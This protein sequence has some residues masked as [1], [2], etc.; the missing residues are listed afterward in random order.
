MQELNKKVAFITGGTK[1]IG[2]GIAEALLKER[3]SIAITGRQ[4]K[5]L[6]PVVEELSRQARQDAKILGFEDD[7]RTFEDLQKAVKQTVDALGKIDILIAN[8]GVGHFA[9]I[10]KLT[11][12]QW[13]QTIDTNLTG[14]FYTLKAG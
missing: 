11:I 2:R 12:E 6:D 8:A 1:G 10:E 9:P 14:V 3:I 13:Q 4:Q 5:T 7:V